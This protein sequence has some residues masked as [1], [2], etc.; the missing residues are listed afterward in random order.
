MQNLKNPFGIHMIINDDILKPIK[1]RIT[2]G[3]LIVGYKW[4]Q[5]FLFK[6][7]KK[8]RQELIKET[9]DIPIAGHLGVYKTLSK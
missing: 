3:E 1:D 7:D 6:D 9:H 4:E 2:E 8:Y 5:G